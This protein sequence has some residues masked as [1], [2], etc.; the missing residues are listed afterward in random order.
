MRHNVQLLFICRAVASYNYIIKLFL[1]YFL[2]KKNI[3]YY[4]TKAFRLITRAK[5]TVSQCQWLA[6]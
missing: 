5:Y 2:L 1:S 4:N 3:K 6:Q